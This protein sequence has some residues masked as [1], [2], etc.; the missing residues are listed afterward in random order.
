MAELH[1]DIAVVR[2]IGFNHAMIGQ[3][4]ST[5]HEDAST[6]SPNLTKQEGLRRLRRHAVDAL[7]HGRHA[8]L[9]G[10]TIPVRARSLLK[11]AT[12]YSREEL[13]EEPGVGT[14]TATE[15]QL[16]LEEQGAALRP[17]M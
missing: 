2:M 12:A 14:V 17:S 8:H 11:I 15:I 6:L 1:D 9:G 4:L 10:R 7:L 3:V 13:L 5:R 16:W